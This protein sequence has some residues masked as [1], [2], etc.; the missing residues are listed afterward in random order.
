[1]TDRNDADA[2]LLQ[3]IEH[4]RQQPIPDF[5]DPQIASTKDGKWRARPIRFVSKIRRIVM[6]RRFQLSAGAIVALA[7]VLGF[8]LLWGGGTA[9]QASAM[10]K[11]ADSIRKARSFKAS[12]IA[13]SKRDSRADKFPF[14]SRVV[15]TVYWLAPGSYR[16][17]FKGNAPQDRGGAT[18]DA[19]VTKIDLSG[20]PRMIIIDHTAKRF[21]KVGKPKRD[22]LGPEI[23][24]ELGKFSGKA[25][26]ELG[27]KEIDGK[28]SR[29]F[30]IDIRKIMNLPDGA[31]NKTKGMVEVWIDP[32]YNL[33]VLVQFNFGT[34][35]TQQTGETGYF[36]LH[37]FQWNIDLDPKLFDITVPERYTDTT[38]KEPSTDERVR[39]FTACLK[40]YVELTGG[41][42][43]P[44][45]TTMPETET[46]H[47]ELL[48]ASGFQWPP[49][50]A[51]SEPK[52]N[53]KF[54]KIQH[55]LGGLVGIAS[56][57]QFLN[58]D[59]A[60]YGKTVRPAD[61]NKVL[62]RWKLDDGRYEVIFGD[63]RAETV[64]AERLRALE[65]SPHQ[66]SPTEKR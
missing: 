64:T 54:Q 52:N 4:L 11:M 17:D 32:E 37:S 65:G 28:K 49:N 50:A 3:V 51:S 66:T 16:F 42:D 9:Q 43:Y 13:E 47:R 8:V 59:A 44:Q 20:Q 10:E 34:N 24:E 58:P 23:L 18:R 39:W 26:R 48:K 25:D 36:R 45:A 22:P 33:P 7:A 56:L 6:N 30:E 61:K 63:L 38:P 27:I 46:T 55:V 62:L 41:K 40:E 60:Y 5:P 15:G 12:V 21:E 29:G 2:L 35:T 57:V 14:T 19:D 53:E 31:A 1:M